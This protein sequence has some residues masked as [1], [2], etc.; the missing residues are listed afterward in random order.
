MKI[1]MSKI[2]YWHDKYQVTLKLEDN[3]IKIFKV[4]PNSVNINGFKDYVNKKNQLQ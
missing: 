1:K 3:M 2:Y 4:N